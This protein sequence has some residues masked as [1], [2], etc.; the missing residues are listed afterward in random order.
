[1][2]VGEL[3][4]AAGCPNWA[5]GIEQAVI[6]AI[7]AHGTPSLDDVRERICLV[8]ARELLSSKG[9][10]DETYAAGEK[11]M[12]LESVVALVASIGSFSMTCMTANHFRHR[13]AG[14]QPDPAHRI[15]PGPPYKVKRQD[16]Y[17]WLDQPFDDDRER[18]G[19]CGALADLRLD[20]NSSAV[21]LDAASFS[22]VGDACS[23]EPD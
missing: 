21:H 22:A 1:V 17:L 20:P 13:S 19:K 9:L 14:C 7:N 3:A 8:V 15:A 6:D 2:I 10:S 12:G 4:A 18:E 23:R 16:A 11:T 5:V